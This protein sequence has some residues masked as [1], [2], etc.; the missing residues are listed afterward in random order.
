MNPQTFFSKIVIFYKNGKVDHARVEYKKVYGP[1][2]IIDLTDYVYAHE[3]NDVIA[4]IMKAFNINDLN[5]LISRGV[6]EYRDYTAI[7]ER[8]KQLEE[9]FRK[10][11]KRDDFDN[12]VLAN[13]VYSVD[14]FNIRVKNKLKQKNISIRK[15]SAIALAIILGTTGIG[16]TVNNIVNRDVISRNNVSTSIVA[17]AEENPEISLR[18]IDNVINQLNSMDSEDDLTASFS[19]DLVRQIVEAYS[20]EFDSP[21]EK[22]VIDKYMRLG[23]LYNV[24]QM[25]STLLNNFCQYA[26]NL[27]MGG[28][29]YSYLYGASSSIPLSIE[30]CDPKLRSGVIEGMADKYH[31]SRKR[32][33]FYAVPG[34]SDIYESFPAILRYA[35]LCQVESAVCNSHFEF[36]YSDVPSWWT[37][38]NFKYDYNRLIEEIRAKKASCLEEIRNYYSSN[39]VKKN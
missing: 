36:K 20:K 18:D 12:S 27:V 14:D 29:N 35:I 31:V 34:E 10:A 23:G 19:M 28:D 33:E 3:L 11:R 30:M 13:V 22:V 24:N 6:I 9:N 38:L 8:D 4:N 32:V 15:I 1:K 37:G 21:I 26:V 25:S 5:F 17:M 16:F 2:Q 7:S 39:G